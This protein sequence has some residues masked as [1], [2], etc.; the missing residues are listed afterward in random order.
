MVEGVEIVELEWVDEC[1][2][3]GGI[4]VIN[5]FDIF[6]KMGKDCIVDYVWVGVEV[7]IVGDMFCLMYFEG[8]L[9]W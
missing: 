6:V 1:C 8:L 4:F 7:I 2:G 5:E 3:F 9:K